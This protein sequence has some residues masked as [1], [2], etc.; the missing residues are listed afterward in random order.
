MQ[1][2]KA[3]AALL[4][5]LAWPGPGLVSCCLDSD[6]EGGGLGLGELGGTHHGQGLGREEKRGCGQ[7]PFRSRYTSVWTGWRVL[8]GSWGLRLKAG[9]LSQLTLRSLALLDGDARKKLALQSYLSAVVFDQ[10]SVCV[11]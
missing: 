7:E 6:Q 4:G 3:V 5:P 2:S 9:H 10:F 11:C 8:L 1:R